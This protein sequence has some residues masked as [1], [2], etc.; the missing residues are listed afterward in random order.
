MLLTILVLPNINDG[1]NKSK[2][3]E[4]DKEKSVDEIL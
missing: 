2:A 4:N 3:N 1:D